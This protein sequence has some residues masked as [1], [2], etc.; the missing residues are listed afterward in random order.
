MEKQKYL[1]SACQRYDGTCGCAEPVVQDGGRWFILIG[2]AGF[3]SPANNA[4]GYASKAGALRE[5][6]RCKGAR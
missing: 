6:R 2:H 3:N 1:V 4:R 5:H